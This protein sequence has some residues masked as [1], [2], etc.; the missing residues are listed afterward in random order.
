M[1]MSLQIAIHHVRR[2]RRGLIQESRYPGI[3]LDTLRS[4]FGQ[5][6][7]MGVSALLSV[8]WQLIFHKGQTMLNRSAMIS[9]VHKPSV[10]ISMMAL[11]NY[12]LK[13]TF[14]G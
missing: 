11:T 7:I 3:F 5:L 2:P 10:R 8:Q 14:P 12:L 1:L 13:P 9:G 6:L 4:H